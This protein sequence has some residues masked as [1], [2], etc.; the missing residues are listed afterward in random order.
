MDDGS[1][2]KIG[3]KLKITMVLFTVRLTFFSYCRA[4]FF[5]CIIDQGLVD[6]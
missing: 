3:T 4:R 2:K 6:R 1:K 5:E